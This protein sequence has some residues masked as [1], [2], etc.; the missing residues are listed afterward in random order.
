MTLYGLSRDCAYRE[1]GIR[2]RAVWM[3]D[4]EAWRRSRGIK[5][6]VGRGFCLSFSFFLTQPF[7]CLLFFLRRNTIS[8]SS[9][10]S[11]LVL[12]CH[13]STPDLVSA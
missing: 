11:V 4:E 9:I 6:I 10:S 1:K 3:S 5:R 7:V 8:V 12:I 13:I 2:L